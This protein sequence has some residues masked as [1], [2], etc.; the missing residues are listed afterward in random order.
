MPQEDSQLVPCYPRQQ[1]SVGVYSR[2]MQRGFC[3]VDIRSKH[4]IPLKLLPAYNVKPDTTPTSLHARADCECPRCRSSFGR[5]D[6]FF[7]SLQTNK[8][9]RN[10]NVLA[11]TVTEAR[12]SLRQTH[13][14]IADLTQHPQFGLLRLQTEYKNSEQ[15]CREKIDEVLQFSESFLRS[16]VEVPPLDDFRDY[17]LP[18]AAASSLHILQEV[19]KQVGKNGGFIQGVTNESFTDLYLS[20]QRLPC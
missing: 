15:T 13:R 14:N 6:L 5:F 16:F 1:I 12:H 4:Y 2:C 9:A 10:I 19:G 3:S 8:A 20:W 17:L 11:Q 7:L 18:S